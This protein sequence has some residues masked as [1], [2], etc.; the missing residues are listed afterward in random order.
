MR[1]RMLR[2]DEEKSSLSLLTD[3]SLTD[4]VVAIVWPLR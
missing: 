2:A 1:T 4:N 3:L